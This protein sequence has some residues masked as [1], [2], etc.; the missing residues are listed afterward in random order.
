MRQTIRRLRLLL[1]L[2]ALLS[3]ARCGIEDSSTQAMDVSALSWAKVAPEQ[4]T[5]AKKHGVPVAF[6]NELGMRFVLIPAG[7][8]LRGTPSDEVRWSWETRQHAVTISRPFYMAIFE[9]TNGQ[10]RAFRPDHDS[11][12]DT[13]FGYGNFGAARTAENDLNGDRQPAVRI[14]DVDAMAFSRWLGMRERGRSYALPNEAEWHYACRAGSSTTF[15]WG[16][17]PA[18]AAKYANVFDG[19]RRDRLAMG[20]LV[21]SPPFLRHVEDD[22]FIVTAP[23]GSYLPNAWCLFDMHGNASEWCRDWDSKLTAEAVSDPQGPETGEKRV[24]AGGNFYDEMYFQR[25]S[26]RSSRTGGSGSGVPMIGFRLVSPL[27]DPGER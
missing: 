12:A 4:I 9:V 6:E 26:S 1:V 19:K 25:A 24:T 21:A 8:F 10:F 13:G 23:V 14:P 17:N 7:T 2:G 16:D 27:P 18:D 15:A 11:G 20:A 22:G 3:L 5:A